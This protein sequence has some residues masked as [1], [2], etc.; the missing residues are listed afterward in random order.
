[1]K[2]ED[3]AGRTLTWSWGAWRQM[4]CG[5][6]LSALILGIAF[7]GIQRFQAVPPVVAESAPGAKGQ[8][9]GLQAMILPREGETVHAGYAAVA[10]PGGDTV[11]AAQSSVFRTAAS[12]QFVVDV[13]STRVEEDHF[14]RVHANPALF[15]SVRSDAHFVADPLTVGGRARATF[16]LDRPPGQF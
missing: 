14:E 6:G 10:G 3:P 2:D 4:V 7:V 12:A 13:L 16:L 1:M 8:T 5:T 11:A 15:G 9:D